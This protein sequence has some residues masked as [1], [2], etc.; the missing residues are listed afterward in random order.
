MAAPTKPAPKVVTQAIDPESE[1][2]AVVETPT[3]PSSSLALSRFEFEKGRGND[4]TKVLMVEWDVAAATAAVGATP[5]P[6]S[7]R[8]D[9][10]QVNTYSHD[11]ADWEVSWEGKTHVLPIRDSDSTTGSVR[12]VYFLLPPGAH[13]P[14]LITITPSGAPNG[15]SASAAPTGPVLRTKP[16]PAIFP[17]GLPGAADREVGRRG[18]LHTIWARKRLGEL[19]AE[20][21]TEAAENAESI[22]LEIAVQERDWIIHEFGVGGDGKEGATGGAPRAHPMS[23]TMPSSPRSPVGGRMGEKL[24]GLKLATSPGDLAAATQA[25]RSARPPQTAGI[26]V[27]S[28]ATFASAQDVGQAGV[29]SLNAVVDSSAA[30]AAAAATRDDDE[31]DMFALPMSPR[32]PEMKKSPFSML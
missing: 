32:S 5:T 21:A 31:D 19:E 26:A 17:A 6:T 27:S 16:L 13:V 22:G 7:A 1:K 2:L 18:V 23:P 28:F 4:G 24:R 9:K 30:A 25:S 15:T 11:G 10:K 12:R 20:I 29:V 8:G 3:S 14:P